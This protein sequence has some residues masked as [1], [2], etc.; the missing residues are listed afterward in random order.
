M[1]FIP[2][3]IIT[4]ATDAIISARDF[5]GDEKEAVRDVLADHNIRD[6]ADR[7]K[8]WGIAKAR[9]NKAW[10]RARVE[11]GV[12]RVATAKDWSALK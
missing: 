7:N 10:N 5:C 1:S 4:E 9:A 8:V 2:E 12:T 3:N 11:A 6:R